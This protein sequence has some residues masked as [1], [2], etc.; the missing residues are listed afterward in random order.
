MNET[1]SPWHITFT[2]D[3]VVVCCYN[4]VLWFSVGSVLWCGSC[5]FSSSVNI[6]LRTE[7]LAAFH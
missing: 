3:S 6:L 7:E 1:L 5:V 2:D 4:C